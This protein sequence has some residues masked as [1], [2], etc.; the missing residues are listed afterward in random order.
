MHHVDVAKQ[1]PEAYQREGDLD[2]KRPRLGFCSMPS[3]TEARLQGSGL[4][5]RCPFVAKC[6]P[7]ALWCF[8]A[9]ARLD[10]L[11]AALRRAVGK[12]GFASVI[13]FT[14]IKL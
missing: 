14:T 10:Q 13:T 1:I 9:G 6:L 4:I 7:L 5:V 2:R 12:Y 3:V 8:K 11:A